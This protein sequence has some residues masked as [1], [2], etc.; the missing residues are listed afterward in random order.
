MSLPVWLWVL[1]TDVCTSEVVTKVIVFG[2]LID[3]QV[4]NCKNKRKEIKMFGCS[5]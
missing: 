3:L 2:L 5:L 1:G 4:E